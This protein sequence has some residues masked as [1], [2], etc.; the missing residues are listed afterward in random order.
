MARLNSNK[1]PL[2]IL[3]L[4]CVSALLWACSNGS[5][6]NSVVIDTGDPNFPGYVIVSLSPGTDLETR[7]LDALINAEPKTIIELPAGTYDFVGELSVSVDNIVLRGQGMT[8]DTGTVLRFD[9]Q[10]TGSQSILATGNN[11]VVEDLAVENSPGD[12]IKIKDS[13]GVPFAA[14]V[15]SG[16][17]GRMKTTAPTGCIL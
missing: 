4:I 9:G 6:N 11:F 7:T 17:M 12:A 13:N 5:N 1:T 16:P 2:N 14:Y 15:S 10:T 8:A 3:L